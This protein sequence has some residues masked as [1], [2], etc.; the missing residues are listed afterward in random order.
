MVGVTYRNDSCRPAGRGRTIVPPLQTEQEAKANKVTP[1]SFRDKESYQELFKPLPKPEALPPLVPFRVEIKS[2][3]QL[4]KEREDMMNKEI[5]KTR[6]EAVSLWDRSKL[7]DDKRVG[8]ITTE[9][10]RIENEQKMRNEILQKENGER[11]IKDKARKEEIRRQEE[12]LSGRKIRAKTTDMETGYV[13]PGG[14]QVYHYKDPVVQKI[15]DHTKKEEIRRRMS[16]GEVLHLSPREESTQEPQ[17]ENLLTQAGSNEIVNFA[18]QSSKADENSNQ[19]T[20]TGSNGFVNISRQSFN[21]EE[22]SKE[23]FKT[24]VMLRSQ[25][26]ASS[27]TSR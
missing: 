11:L 5:E 24:N 10:N 16:H 14:I 6:Q 3:R 19:L 4:Q 20:K 25:S 17:A 1:P 8:M 2:Y 9:K 22:N 23:V 27:T 12:L 15:V 21:T 26:S 18:K 7:E 13:N